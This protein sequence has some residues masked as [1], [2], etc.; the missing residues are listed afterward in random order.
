MCLP[1]GGPTL[2]EPVLTWARR[3]LT[4]APIALLII[5]LFRFSFSSWV[6]LGHLHFPPPRARLRLEDPWQDGYLVGQQVAARLEGALVFTR[7]TVSH[8]GLEPSWPRPARARQKSH[9]AFLQKPAGCGGLPC[10]VRRPHEGWTPLVGTLEADVTVLCVE[11][12]MTVTVRAVDR[13]ARYA[14]AA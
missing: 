5:G 10:S 9:K 13:R 7:W 14:P 12:L 11:K 1:R 6:S 8:M 3:C 4:T 2:V